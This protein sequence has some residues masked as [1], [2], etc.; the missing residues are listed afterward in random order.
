MTE[1]PVI[2]DDDWDEALE[3]NS[4]ADC[5]DYRGVCEELVRKYIRLYKTAL[6]MAHGY[7]GIAAEQR[8]A[9]LLAAAANRLQQ[10]GRCD[11]RGKPK[12]APPCTQE[13][14]ER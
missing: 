8:S 3:N 6:D 11:E 5:T 1:K 4:D 10:D 13:G 7:G 9:Q 14:G 12:P 2:A